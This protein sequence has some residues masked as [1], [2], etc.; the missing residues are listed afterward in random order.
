MEIEILK[1]IVTEQ[2]A[3]LEGT[4]KEFRMIIGRNDH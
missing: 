1:R 3:E 4:F 2:R